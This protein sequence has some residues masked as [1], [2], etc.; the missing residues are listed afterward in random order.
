VGDRSWH[1]CIGVFVVDGRACGAYG[2]LAERALIDSAAR[3]VAV[4]VARAELTDPPIP[5]IV[6]SIGVRPHESARTV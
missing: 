3:D 2:R 5:T 6:P 4:L 1:P